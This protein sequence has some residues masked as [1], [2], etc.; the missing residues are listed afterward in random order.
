MKYCRECNIDIDTN[1][2]TCPF[3][4]DILDEKNGDKTKME[5]YESYKETPYKNPMVRK[6]F[7]FISL[8]SSIV[9]SLPSTTLFTPKSLKRESADL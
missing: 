2:V 1:R 5:K 6:I 4:R 7:L 8:I 3:C 9:H